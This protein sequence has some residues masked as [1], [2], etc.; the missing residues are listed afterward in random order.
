MSM[1]RG[2]RVFGSS[3]R[4]PAWLFAAVLFW[5]PAAAGAG[6]AARAAGIG[7]V[8]LV[9]GAVAAIIVLAYRWQKRT[10]KHLGDALGTAPVV[11]GRKYEA[12]IAGQPYR[13]QYVPGSRNSP[14]R[15]TVGVECVSPGAFKVKKEKG[16]DRLFKRLGIAEEIQ[17]GDPI[18]D[19]D[20][21]LDTE[22]VAFTRSYFQDHHKRE[23]MV[24]LFQQGFSRVVHDGKSIQATIQPFRPGD[25]REPDLIQHAVA[26]LKTLASDLPEQYYE[27]RIAGAAAWKVKRVLIFAV[28]VASAAAAVASL[29]TNFRFYAA[30]D[31]LDAFLVSLRYSVPALVMFGILAVSWL[32]GRSSSHLEVTAALAGALLAFPAGGFGLLLFLNGYLDTSPTVQHRAEAVEKHYTRSKDSTTYH[33]VLRSWREGRSREEIIVS[34][35][36]Y[37]ATRPGASEITVGTRAGRLGFQWVESYR[38]Q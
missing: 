34:R 7:A 23:A 35:S 32:K 19:Q 9:L 11:P 6:S 14:P 38:L 37:A 5:P 13:Y 31:K 20:L 2:F 24:G 27:P 18:F 29:A 16:F 10:L 1:H 21:Y 4:T 26:A 8:L 30:L 36:V 17:T 12:E 22:S 15:F 33:V 25:S 28:L 3:G